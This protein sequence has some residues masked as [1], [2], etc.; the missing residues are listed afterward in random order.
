MFLALVL[1]DIELFN[2]MNHPRWWGK[3]ARERRS[4]GAK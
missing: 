3:S 2:G 1:I 4:Q